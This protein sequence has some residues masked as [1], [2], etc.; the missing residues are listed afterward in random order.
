MRPMAALCPLGLAA[1]NSIQEKYEKGINEAFNENIMLG[2]LLRW[3]CNEPCVS[4][5]KRA[6]V[7]SYVLQFNVAVVQD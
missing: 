3:S 6:A 4:A 2:S 7:L 1:A 5:N